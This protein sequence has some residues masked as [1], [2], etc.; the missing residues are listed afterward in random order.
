MTPLPQPRRSMRGGSQLGAARALDGVTAPGVSWCFRRLW[1]LTGWVPAC[2]IVAVLPPTLSCFPSSLPWPG[3][4][5]GPDRRRRPADSGSGLVSQLQH[6]L[7]RHDTA[8]TLEEASAAAK[9]VT[10]PLQPVAALVMATARSV[11]GNSP[12]GVT[13]AGPLPASH[14]VATVGDTAAAVLNQA[15][16]AVTT[17]ATTAAPVL[18]EAAEDIDQMAG[19]VPVTLPVSALP[20]APFPLPETPGQANTAAATLSDLSRESKAAAPLPA[21]PGLAPAHLL[22]NSPAFPAMAAAAGRLAPST[23]PDAPDA[24]RPLRRS[25][26]QSHSGS[27]YPG[28]GG[29]GANA[30]GDLSGFWNAFPAGKSARMPDM[31]QNPAASPPF[32]PGSSPD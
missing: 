4:S 20:T 2:V 30:A 18:T 31:T 25:A 22:F 21:W 28:P 23:Q 14:A 10:Q 24:E 26:L 29:A 17:V 9:A 13:Q 15:V 16:T 8:S 3:S 1:G 11:P 7:L 32:D 12:T 27:A 5:G 6:G 19:A